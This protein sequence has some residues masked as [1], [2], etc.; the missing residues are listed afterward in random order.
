MRNNGMSC[1]KCRRVFNVDQLAKILED[2]GVS[3]KTIKIV[4]NELISKEVAESL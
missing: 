1:P 2:L 3:K 4:E